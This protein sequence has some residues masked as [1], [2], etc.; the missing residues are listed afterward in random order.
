MHEGVSGWSEHHFIIGGGRGGFSLGPGPGS[1]KK[2][3]KNEDR[4][5]GFDG[6]PPVFFNFKVNRP[7]VNDYKRQIQRE[8]PKLNPKNPF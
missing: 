5:E 8:D 7:K 2:K 1:R 3:E 4:F 6:S